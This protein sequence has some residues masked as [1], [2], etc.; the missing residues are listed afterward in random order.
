M[1]LYTIR[2]TVAEEHGPIF[3]ALNDGVAKR[4][5]RQMLSKEVTHP[6]EYDLIIVG[7]VDKKTML[8]S[9]VP[10]KVV[11]NGNGAVS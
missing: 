4:A 6:E 7:T 3:E 5:F 1:N 2:D 8:V 11:C 10:V 9:A